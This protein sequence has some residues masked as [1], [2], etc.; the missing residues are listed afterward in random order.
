MRDHRRS[1]S[2][3]GDMVAVAL[4]LMSGCAGSAMMPIA[5]YQGVKG[6]INMNKRLVVGESQWSA[7]SASR[8]GMLTSEKIC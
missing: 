7:A 6:N 1:H 8:G 3:V 5:S 2:P 4:P